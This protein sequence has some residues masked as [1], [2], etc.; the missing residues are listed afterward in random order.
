ML[1]DLMVWSLCRMTSW[2]CR[3]AVTLV[4][5]SSCFCVLA[6]ATHVRYTWPWLPPPGVGVGAG[7]G[8]Q[9]GLS[10]GFSPQGIF[11]PHMEISQAQKDRKAFLAGGTAQTKA[12]RGAILHRSGPDTMGPAP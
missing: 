8:A 2:I 10:L 9:R 11:R 12:Q 1:T 6:S 5:S 3:S 4:S 7:Q